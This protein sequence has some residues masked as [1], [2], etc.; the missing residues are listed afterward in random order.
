LILTA[1][2]HEVLVVGISV[3]LEGGSSGKSNRR[4]GDVAG[5]KGG[6]VEEI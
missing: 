2:A 4:H 5:K 6:L 3:R 1:A